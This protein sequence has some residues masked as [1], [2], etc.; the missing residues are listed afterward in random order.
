MTARGPYQLLPPMSDEEYAALRDDIAGAGVRVPIDVDE[1][2]NILDGHHRKAIADELGKPCPERVVRD[3]PE[4]AKVDYALSVNL[5]RRHLSAEQKKALVVKS[6][7]RDPRLS[8]REHA[9]RC[10]VSHS[11][12]ATLRDALELDSQ[13][14]AIT[15]RTGRDGKAYPADRT[16][17]VDAASTSPPMSHR[18]DTP[19]EADGSAPSEAGAGVQSPAP[20]PQDG[21][22]PGPAP[23]GVGAPSGA[24]DPGVAAPAPDA[25]QA[26]AASGTAAAGDRVDPPAAADPDPID[27]VLDALAEISA[28]T[29]ICPACQRPLAT[30]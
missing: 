16:P 29:G 6:L 20:A 30:S 10:G 13:I 17:K 7:K 24:P 19:G 26:S 28:E 4:F 23:E 25:E 22:L 8:N 11:Y 12:V 15:G 9:R 1:A 5:A 2:G 21:L 18:A 3:L 14:D 27:Q